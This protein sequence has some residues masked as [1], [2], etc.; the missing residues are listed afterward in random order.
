MEKEPLGLIQQELPLFPQSDPVISISAWHKE[1]GR[2]KTDEIKDILARTNFPDLMR[3]FVLSDENE[4]NLRI[5][6]E[7]DHEIKK[8]GWGDID[9]AIENTRFYSKRFVQNGHVIWGYNK[10]SSVQDRF[11]KMTWVFPL[12]MYVWILCVI[13]T[14]FLFF[15]MIAI[16]TPGEP[17]DASACVLL[18]FL[19]FLIFDIFGFP[20]VGCVCQSFGFF[21]RFNEVIFNSFPLIEF[22]DDC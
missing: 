19:G 8:Y 13:V 18:V 1:I 22:Q 15:F 17:N 2:A 5:A 9:A 20:V 16:S 11:M 4:L 21:E 6:E 12:Y 3:A 14:I 10:Q 7:V